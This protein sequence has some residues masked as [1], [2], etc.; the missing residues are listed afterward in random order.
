MPKISVIMGVYREK[1]EYLQEA[2]LSILKQTWT[3]LE[4]LVYLDGDQPELK[5]V[6]KE[7]SR[8]DKRIHILEEKKN[9]GLGHGLNVCIAEASG[10][11]LARMDSDDL[12][13]PDRLEHQVRFLEQ[14]PDCD[15]VGC[16]TLLFDNH[17]VY[18]SR[19]MKTEPEK[20]DFYDYLPFV[21]PSVIFRAEIFSGG[22]RY[23]ESKETL[24]SE[25]LVLFMELY[26]RGKKGRNLQEY[27]Y[28]YRE[29]ANA[30]EKKKYRYRLIESRVR[31]EGYDQLQLQGAKS[32]LYT[33][34]PLVVGLIPAPLMFV[35]KRQRDVKEIRH[36]TTYGSL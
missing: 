14:H 16:N 4:L 26:A 30:F 1:K 15:F 32:W 7:M 12:S 5:K 2:I 25:D 27:L 10:E 34:K 21:H 29:D 22:I 17:G 19:K 31:R 13:E 18:G 6:V 33:V 36:G 9:Y 20:E 28:R 24:R 3:D 23:P 11:Y 35:I 8:K